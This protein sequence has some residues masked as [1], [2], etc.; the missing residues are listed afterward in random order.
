MMSEGLVV[1]QSQS[2]S[3]GQISDRPKLRA[4]DI[5]FEILTRPAI[6][7]KLTAKYDAG[8]SNSQHYDYIRRPRKHSLI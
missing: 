7:A 8:V 1:T 6:L 5:S 3:K 2:G 4:E